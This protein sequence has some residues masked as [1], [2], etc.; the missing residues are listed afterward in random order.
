MSIFAFCA[1]SVYTLIREKC[2]HSCYQLLSHFVVKKCETNLN[3]YVMTNTVT[4]E[5]MFYMA[6]IRI[7]FEYNAQN[8]S[9]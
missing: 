7:P 5:I 9:R 8:F 4:L 2:V 1:Y 3:K 6:K